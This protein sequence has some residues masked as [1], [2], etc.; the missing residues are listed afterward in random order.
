M[1]KGE[2]LADQI[3]N[4][5]Q[6]ES[7]YRERVIVFILACVSP[8]I[9]LP[10]SLLCLLKSKRNWRTHIFVISLT[11]AIFS[12][13][14]I[15]IGEC[16]LTRYFD[17]IKELSDY[18]F[19][20]AIL[21]VYEGQTNLFIF[22]AVGWIV[23]KLYDEHLL[24]AISVFFVYYI[25]LYI[26]CSISEK[27]KID[28]KHLRVYLI[29]LICA[30][31]WYGMTNNVRNILA[32][33]IVLLAVYRDFC[34]DKRNIWTVIL[35]IL[36]IFIHPTAILLVLLRFGINV[37]KKIKIFMVALIVLVNPIIEF[38][39]ATVSIAIDNSLFSYIII[40]MHNYFFDTGSAWG[41]EVS[42]SIYYFVHKIIYISTTILYCLLYLTVN[43][44]CEKN[45]GID[46]FQNYIFLLGLM[47][48]S[49][50]KMLRPEYWRFTAIVV[51]GGSCIILPILQKKAKKLVEKI[52]I[53]WFYC[54][55]PCWLVLQ[56]YREIKLNLT[57]LVYC[58]IIN[59]PIII[60]IKDFI[61][62]ILH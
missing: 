25:A 28:N 22:N 45:D 31:D 58:S 56:M 32:F 53:G 50:V 38:L 2:K 24:P 40:K 57:E 44:K 29:F 26:T 12:Y 61:I 41:L 9:A 51:V 10:I 18:S 17:Y 14:Y 59:P 60:A 4:L 55:I 3:Y 62:C 7:Q 49:C 13:S 33:S 27:Q 5:S 42:Q 1:T 16:D 54:S 15:P 23:E 19:I 39:Y 43:D 48:I 47:A 52:C 30:I 36:P 21:H 34:L 6:G 46:K 20:G 8:L 37:T 35:Y 11:F